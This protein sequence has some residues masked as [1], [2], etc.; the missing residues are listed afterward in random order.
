M[1]KYTR[2]KTIEITCPQCRGADVVKNGKA[3]GRQRF[4]CR[5]CGRTFSDSGAAKGMRYTPDQVGEAVGLYY[6]GLSYKS[7]ASHME[8]RYEMP[9]PSKKTIYQWVE[10]YTDRAVREMESH[11]AQ[12][13]D[14]WVVDEMQVRVGG[15]PY[16]NWNVMD[17]ETRYVLASYL[18][19]YRNARAAATVL[20]KA[21]ANATE[22]PKTIKTD[23]LKSYPPAIRGVFGDK[24]KHVQSDGIAAEVN[25]NRSERLQ[26][27]YR[28]RTKTL[29][30]LQSR[31]SG[32]DY[33]D[34]WTLNY[35]LFTPHR[36]LDNRT[37]AQAAKID[38]PFTSWG[39]VVN[40][41]QVFVVQ[42][43]KLRPSV[44]VEAD[45]KITSQPQ[46]KTGRVKHEKPMPLRKGSRPRRAKSGAGRHPY[47]AKRESKSRTPAGARR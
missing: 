14:E 4:L 23:R 27:S 46:H 35:N 21:A 11:P 24:V 26:G 9:R 28:Q 20:R 10:D 43:V 39:G 18:S 34:G 45:P 36:S 19:R 38:R 40:P 33:L 13:G 29:R 44:L 6:D 30:G 25:N 22:P 1:A 15:K 31:A 2:T 41:P 32:Q 5:A 47:L 17:S 12:T 7:I 16:W 3:K 37:P 8:R 42:D